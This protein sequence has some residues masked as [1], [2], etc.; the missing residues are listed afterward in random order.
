MNKEMVIKMIKKTIVYERV[1]QWGLLFCL[2]PR[3]FGKWV[4]QKQK[5]VKKCHEDEIWHPFTFNVTHSWIPTKNALR[6]REKTGDEE[7]YRNKAV[8]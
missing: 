5:T 2:A 3:T 6:K 8:L 7:K 1:F 4:K